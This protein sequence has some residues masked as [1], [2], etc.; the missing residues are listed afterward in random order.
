MNPKPAPKFRGSGQVERFATDDFGRNAPEQRVA[1]SACHRNG[2]FAR[3]KIAK[4]VCS[5]VSVQKFR[6]SARNKTA[7]SQAKSGS[8]EGN[9]NWIQTEASPGEIASS[10]SHQSGFGNIP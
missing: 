9:V 7:N 10:A 6:P 4:V 3:C 2:E 1:S 5:V 8:T